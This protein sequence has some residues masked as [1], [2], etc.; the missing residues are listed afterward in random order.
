M[1]SPSP[2]PDVRPEVRPETSVLDALSLLGDV[3]DQLVVAGVRDTHLAWADRAHGS[4]G[5]SPGARRSCPRRSTGASPR[6]CTAA[7]GWGC[8]GPRAGLSRAA[9]GRRA[10]LEAGPRGRWCPPSSTG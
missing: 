3:L 1:P 8:A 9:T 4:C 6:P 10:P 5:G 7:S 2:R